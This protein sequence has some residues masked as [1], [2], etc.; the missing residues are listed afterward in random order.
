MNQLQLPFDGLTNSSDE[1]KVSSLRPIHY[2]GNKLRML[3]AIEAALDQVDPDRGLTCDL[4]S[5]SGVVSSHL[6]GNRRV[7]AVDIQEYSRILSEALINPVRVPEEIVSRVKAPPQ[8]NELG[9]KLMWAVSPLI[10]AEEEYIQEAAYG[11]LW[12]LYD[13][14]EAGSVIRAKIDG[15]HALPESCQSLFSEAMD[16]LS[17]VDLLD[18][19][20]ATATRYYGGLYFG[21][22]QSINLDLL[23][24]RANSMDSKHRNVL[25][26]SVLSTASEVAAT[27]G[28]QFAQPL[29][30]RKN[31]GTPKPNVWKRVAEARSSDVFETFDHWLER[32]CGR[33]GTT[34]GGCA[35]KKDYRKFL[36]S[37][38]SSVSAFYVDPPYTR[39]HYSRYYHVLETLCLRDNPAIT[40]S[41]L[42]GG[43]FVSRGLYRKGRHQSPFCI[44]SRAPRA[45]KELFS[46]LRSFDA[47]AVV[48]YS[49]GSRQGSSR[50]RVMEI[51]EVVSIAE[52]QYSSIDQTA[53]SSFSHSKLTS[54]EQLLDTPEESEI[55]LICKP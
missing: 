53:L 3:D 8:T 25:T 17:Q 7:V 28:N 45:F 23:L 26:A 16:R 38:N 50:P 2:L 27:V 35:V 42:N 39:D 29:R 55:L 11:N 9:E 33:T 6:V 13:L 51:Q 43:K 34:V 30:P 15:T 31:D 49:P 40:K 47:P 36:K 10:S 37:F 4:F 18:S 21:F 41:N 5:G 20:D 19:P 22:R 46:L 32:Y 14:L 1:G 44:K 54:K 24:S 48:S 52:Q 12:P